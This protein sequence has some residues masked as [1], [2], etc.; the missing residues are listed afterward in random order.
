[1]VQQVQAETLSRLSADAYVDDSTGQRLTGDQLRRSAGQLLR[2][3]ATTLHVE[4][5]S[6]IVTLH[7]LCAPSAD[8]VYLPA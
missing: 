1:L 3:S 6:G 8:R 2:D 7:P 4:L 5:P